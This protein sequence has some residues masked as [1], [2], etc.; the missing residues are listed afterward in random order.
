MQ[1][2]QHLSIAHDQYTHVQKN[3]QFIIQGDCRLKVLKGK[4][5]VIE[6]RLQRKTGKVDRLHAR[7]E[8]RIKSGSKTVLEAD[9]AITVKAGSSYITIDHDGVHIVGATVSLNEGGAAAAG[10]AFNAAPPILKTTELQSTLLKAIAP[11]E[12]LAKS[13]GSDAFKRSSEDTE[14]AVTA[15]QNALL[16]LGFYLGVKQGNGKYLSNTQLA[17]MYFQRDFVPTGRIHP[18]NPAMAA[19]NGEID[20]I[21]LK[22]LDEA[23][24][25]GWRYNKL[26]SDGLKH[27]LT[28]NHMEQGSK[29]V[30]K[31]ANRQN[32]DDIERIQTGLAELGFTCHVDGGFGGELERAIKRFKRDYKEPSHEIH[33]TYDL[34]KNPDTGVFDKDMLLAL[35]E[36]L[37]ENKLKYT[38]FNWAKSELGTLIYEKEST[39]D[40]SAYN[41]TENGKKKAFYK[42]ELTSWTLADVLEKQVAGEIFAAGGF[43]VINE[44][45]AGDNGAVKALSL[46]KDAPFDEAMQDRIFN[47]FLI[48]RKRPQIMAYLEGESE[49]ISTAMYELAKEFASLPVEEGK[50]LQTRK[51]KNPDGTYQLNPDRTVKTE[52]PIAEGGES[53]YS[54]DGLNAV[55]GLDTDT[56]SEVLKST[57]VEAGKFAKKAFST[58]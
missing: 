13:E 52:T 47:E 32:L 11:L 2:D 6:R 26:Q 23:L 10:T 39:K 5:E 7:K 37:V 41:A 3:Q 15:L 22:A 48:D 40:Y 27:S 28:L 58:K 8:V 24:I 9:H 34:S 30:Y 4:T 35:D 1:H 21:T 46:D 14:G 36:A 49:D 43:Q 51:L 18:D 42:T 45:L 25:E 57:R 17:V 53:Y 38:E 55:H 12:T 19:T 16:Q 56:L 31:F 50:P 20:A 33:P 29:L 44:V 54:G